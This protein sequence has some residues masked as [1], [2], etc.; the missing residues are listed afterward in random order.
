MSLQQGFFRPR[1][2]K[3]YVGDPRQIVFRSS[4]ELTVMKRLDRDPQVKAWASEEV[5]VPYESPIDGWR[6]RYFVDFYVE[7]KDGRQ[8]LVEV[9]PFAQTMPPKK[10]KYKNK[11][12]V[13][14]ALE[15]CKNRAKWAAAE[16]YAA[17]R[18]WEFQILTEKEIFGRGNKN[19]RTQKPVKASLRRPA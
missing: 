19:P 16:A 1:N 5:V 6:H 12:F 13:A 7:M 3:K 2:V 9:K 17:S 10:P 8:L 11:R 15:Y 4:W 18:G 14:E